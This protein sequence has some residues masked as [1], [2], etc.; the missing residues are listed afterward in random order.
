MNEQLTSQ[1][2]QSD[3]ESQIREEKLIAEIHI[4]KESREFKAE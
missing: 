2:K 4:L 1:L 3:A